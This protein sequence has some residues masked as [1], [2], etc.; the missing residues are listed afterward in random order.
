M[1]G[2]L[3]EIVRNSVKEKLA[4]GEVVASMTVR[5]VPTLHDTGLPGFDDVAWNG[6]VAPAGTPRDVL[7]RLHAEIA[8]AVSNPEFRKRFLERG[9]E[10]VASASPEEFSAYVKSEAEDFVKL[11]REANIRAE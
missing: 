5:L 8:R 3:R 6:I 1:Q 7:V 2:Q 4:R 11:A 10:M 9:I